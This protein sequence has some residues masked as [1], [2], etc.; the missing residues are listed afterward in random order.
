MGLR[1]GDELETTG[2]VGTLLLVGV[3]GTA[4]VG[5]ALIVFHSRPENTQQIND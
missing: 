3:L 4:R 5:G 1:G 2:A